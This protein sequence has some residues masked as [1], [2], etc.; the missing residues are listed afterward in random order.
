MTVLAGSGAAGA[1]GACSSSSNGSASDASTD[2]LGGDAATGS[3]LPELACTDS[4]SSVYADPGDVSGKPIGTILKCA[5]DQTLTAAELTAPLGANDAG[6]IA[7]SG[8]AFTSGANVYRV[9]YRTTRGDPN[10]SPGYSSALV[11]LPTTPRL[12]VGSRLPV[13]VSAHGSRGQAGKCAPSLNDPAA[14]DVEEDFQHQIYPLVGLGLPVIAPDLAGYANFGGANNPPPTYSNRLDVGRSLL[15][16]ARALRNLIPSSVTEQVAITGHSQGGATALDALSLADTYGAG[17]VVSAVALYSPLWFSQRGYAGLFF[18]PSDFS[19]EVSHVAGPVSMWWHYTTSYLLDGP[20][21][22]L[23]LFQPSKGAVV[24]SFVD[25]DCWS[26]S[27]PD[28]IAGADDD[29]GPMAAS[30]NDYF[31]QAY[32]S[33]VTVPAIPILSDPNNPC[34]NSAD[35]PTCT[36][37]IGRMTADWPHLTGGATKVPILIY[38]A[39]NDQTLPPDWIQCVFNRLTSDQTDY[40]VCYDTNAVGHSGVVAENA[41]SVADWIASKTLPEAGA[42]Q[43]MN[44][45]TLPVSDAGVPLLPSPDGGTE[46]CYQLLGPQ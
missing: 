6:Q 46:T 36:K 17:G 43:L 39:D 38:Y 22:A 31:T 11:L 40:K 35:V 24:Q 34:A 42:P 20:D 29:A 41:G 3:F 9:L 16:G 4:I 32:Q 1:L 33:A 26:G 25:N 15:D 12:G 13:V 30:A 19:F 5:K 23:E 14:A 44:C 27:Y 7:Y 37:W 28:L 18:L 45:T 21:A 10:N 8:R 2:G